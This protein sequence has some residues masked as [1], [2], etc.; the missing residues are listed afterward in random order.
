MSRK[1]MIMLGMVVGSVVGSFV[2]TLLGA[3]SLS[4]TSLLGSAVG[5]FLGIYLAYRYTD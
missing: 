5:A 2:T 1:S 3:D 4:V